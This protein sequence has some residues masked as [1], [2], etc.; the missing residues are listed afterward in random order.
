MN[1]LLTPQNKA[2][3]A[4]YARSFAAAGIAAYTASGGDPKAV[5]NAIWAA[6]LPVAVRYLNPKDLAFGKGV[7]KK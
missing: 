5:L 1:Q 7:E 2:I 3:A 6:A 4:S